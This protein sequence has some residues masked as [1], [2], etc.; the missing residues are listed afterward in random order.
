MIGSPLEYFAALSPGLSV[1]EVR[2]ELRFSYRYTWTLQG[3]HSTR[4]GLKRAIAEGDRLLVRW[5]EP[6]AGLAS[7]AGG[8]DRRPLLR[9]AWRGHLLNH[10]HDTLGGCVSDDVAKDIAVRAH[11]AITQ[12]RGILLDALHDRL[13]QDR[14][15]ARR[16]PDRWNASLA[17]IN[18]SPWPVSRVVEVTVTAFVDHVVVGRPAPPPPPRPASAVPTPRLLGPDGE[19][20]PVQV[21]EAYDAYQRLDSP[22]AYPDQDLVRAFRVAVFP[23]EIPA[24]GLKALRVEGGDRSTSRSDLREVRA[25]RGRLE[26]SHG[27]VRGD[28]SEGFSWIDREADVSCRGLAAIE[29]DRDEGD[30]YTFQPVE[31][32]RSLPAQWSRA[33]VVWEGPLMASVA[34][35][36]QV[37]DRARGTVHA[38]MEAGSRLV[39]FVVEG[40]NLRRNHRLRVKFP[41]P[42]NARPTR[43]VA[44]M[45]FG[46]VGRERRE[47]DRNAFPKEWP[48]TTAPMHRYVSVA[49]GAGGSGLTVFARG[50]F[51]YE[52]GRGGAVAVT[53][54]RAVGDL[55]RGDLAARP[56][57]AAWPLRTP[58]AQEPGRFRLELAVSSLAVREESEPALWQAMEHLAEEFHAPCA[59]LMLRYG[60]AVP[61]MVE[62]PTLTGSGLAFK[63]LK[64]RE[65]G[66]GVVA[67]CVNLTDTVVEGAWTWP[68]PVA[69]AYEARL[70]ETPIRECPLE[71]GGRQVRFRAAPRAPVTIVVE[72]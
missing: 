11:A 67:R 13:G 65:A 30:T 48:V 68:A 41:L 22:A 12:A 26:A 58:A 27:L 54:F 70:D 51:E 57:H 24:F 16:A 33:R 2:G 3:V 28:G 56:G 20:V 21:L 10:P 69:R 62:G 63:A 17:V 1:P 4:A 9:A 47:Y 35:D 8:S 44:D 52:L 32:D 72:P 31:G 37:G 66:P 14:T 61:A 6:Q 29:S 38:R 50:A 25:T 59:G 53:V 45:Q 7:L 46:W 34:R 5:A 71:A 39:R 64:P 55:S 43:S 23:G 40:T 36:F 19:A 49:T 18:P 42:G 60:I 15:R